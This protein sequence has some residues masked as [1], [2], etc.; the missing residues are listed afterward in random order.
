MPINAM[1]TAVTLEFAV[2]AYREGINLYQCHRGICRISDT[3]TPK[4]HLWADFS[5]FMSEHTLL[6]E[7]T[8]AIHP[9]DWDQWNALRLYQQKIVN[10]HLAILQRCA[11]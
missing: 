5:S 7:P 6:Q 4:V 9:A 2:N 3:R 8:R 10:A 1:R 11:A